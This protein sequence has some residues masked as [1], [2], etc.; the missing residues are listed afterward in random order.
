MNKPKPNTKRGKQILEHLIK[1]KGC[2][3]LKCTKCVFRLYG[4][5]VDQATI[6]TPLRKH[7]NVQ[8]I[9]DVYEKYHGRA[10]LF[11]LLLEQEVKNG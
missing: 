10:A 11:T 1:T 7:K 8:P 3:G 4:E 6:C 2:V 9:C 5:T